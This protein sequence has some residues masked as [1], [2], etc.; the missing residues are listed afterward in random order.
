MTIIEVAKWY[1]KLSYHRRMEYQYEFG[2]DDMIDR[3]VRFYKW[4]KKQI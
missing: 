4:L 3:E 1:D 2:N